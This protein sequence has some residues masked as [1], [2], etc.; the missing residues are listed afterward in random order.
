MSQRRVRAR[1]WAATC[2]HANAEELLWEILLQPVLDHLP[3]QPD[4][5]NRCMKYLGDLV[6]C[7]PPCLGRTHPWRC[8]PSRRPSPAARNPRRIR[9]K[10]DT[11]SSSVRCPTHHWIHTASPPGSGVKL[12]RGSAKK[13]LTTCP[14][15]R[16]DSPAP[17]SSSALPMK[18]ATGSTRSTSSNA[19][20]RKLLVTRPMPAPQSHANFS[21]VVPR[22]LEHSPSVSRRNSAFS[23]AS[24][25]ETWP[26]PPSTLVVRRVDAVPVLDALL[27]PQAA[28]PLL[29]SEPAATAF[30]NV[31]FVPMLFRC[32]PFP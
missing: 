8:S 13:F 7:C 29:S 27:V 2:V 14:S 32:R 19:W 4:P 12:S 16:L 22:L 15:A 9:L 1:S 25:E 31:T 6:N 30:Q 5:R 21:P 10:N 23:R 18:C 28:Y 11:K 17:R 3:A 26:C 20:I 24:T